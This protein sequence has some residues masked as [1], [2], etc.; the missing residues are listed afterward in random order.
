MTERNYSISADYYYSDIHTK[1][2]MEE[3][4]LSLQWYKLLG[5]GNWLGKAV[6]RVQGKGN[7]HG[8]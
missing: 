6:I 8:Q 1:T 5:Q 2:R 4:S 7:H 3:Q